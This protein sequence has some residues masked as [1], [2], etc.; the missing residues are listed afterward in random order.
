MNLQHSEIFVTIYFDDYIIMVHMHA[1][2]T[3]SYWY[4]LL[5]MKMDQDFICKQLYSICLSVLSQAAPPP[6]TLQPQ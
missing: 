5:T 1:W 3:Y 2:L 4:S 6:E